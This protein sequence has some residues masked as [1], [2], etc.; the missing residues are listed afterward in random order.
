MALPLGI[1]LVGM[2]G[3]GLFTAFHNLPTDVGTLPQY[4]GYMIEKARGG[5]GPAAPAP[6]PN[7]PMSPTDNM[8]AI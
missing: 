6:D 5:L 2:G 1:L 8:S 7:R 3:V 4:I